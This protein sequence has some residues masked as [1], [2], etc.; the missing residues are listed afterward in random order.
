MVAMAP[1]ISLGH[2]ACLVDNS[3]GGKDC[4]G[5]W[6]KGAGPYPGASSSSTA[7]TEFKV[8]LSLLLP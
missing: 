7:K 5:P 6:L 2:L 3:L 8:I 4:S 1:I